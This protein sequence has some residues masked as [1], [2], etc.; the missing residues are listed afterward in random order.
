MRQVETPVY[1]FLSAQPTNE[2]HGWQS[3]ILARHQYQGGP[4][5]SCVHSCLDSEQSF[6]LWPDD[7]GACC[8]VFH[9]LEGTVG[10]RSLLLHHT[11]SFRAGARSPRAL[12]Y[13]GIATGPKQTLQ[14]NW[15]HPILKPVPELIS[16]KPVSMAYFLRMVGWEYA[17]F[18]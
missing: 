5:V 3:G 1:D 14:G 8:N 12:Y 15:P 9:L 16:L 4:C 7:S 6:F 11:A 18:T 13:F 2:L 10:H 17:Y